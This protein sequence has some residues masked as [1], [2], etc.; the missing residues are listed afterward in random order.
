MISVSDRDLEVDVIIPAYNAERYIADTMASVFA[1]TRPPARMIVVNDGSTDGTER[2]VQR[3][4]NSHAGPVRTQLL[5]K[6]NGGQSTARNMGIEQS[7]A[8]FLAFL[9]ADDL[10]QPRKL[11]RQM[12][13]FALDTADLGLVYCWHGT[14]DEHGK[15]FPP[16]IPGEMPQGKIFDRMLMA[17]L[18][19]ASASAAVVRRECFTRLGLFDEALRGTE[20]WDMW[21]RIADQY[22]VDRVLEP[23]VLIRQHAASTQADEFTMLRGMVALYVKWFPVAKEDENLMKQWGHLI[24]EFIIRSRDQ[25]GARAH[26]EENLTKEM[27][28]VLFRRTMGSLSFYLRLKRLR[29]SI[30]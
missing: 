15:E 9:D 2:I 17:N 6:K 10:W 13:L 19:N 24:A 23:L 12:E 11:E 3:V 5:N 30:N 22:R 7:T 8:P 20:D 27:K 26:V 14:M 18:I 4:I 25:Q 28:A 16:P 1:Q 21:I 29:R